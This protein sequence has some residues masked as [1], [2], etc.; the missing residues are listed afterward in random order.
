MK[1]TEEVIQTIK[2]QYRERAK[3]LLLNEYNPQKGDLDSLCALSNILELESGIYML[4]ILEKILDGD[5]KTIKRWGL[6]GIDTCKNTVEKCIESFEMDDKGL[7]GL[8]TVSGEKVSISNELLGYLV[9]TFDEKGLPNKID[10]TEEGYWGLQISNKNDTAT[11][12]FENTKIIMDLMDFDT[13]KE[14]IREIEKM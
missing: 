14:H 5:E 12:R 3:N 2:K 6:K 8:Y 10:L 4:N 7:V 9:N 1:I 11:I 13:L